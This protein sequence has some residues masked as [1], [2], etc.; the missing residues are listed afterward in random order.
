VDV[1]YFSL[2][3]L[4]LVTAVLLGSFS[5]PNDVRNQTIHTITT[6]PVERYEIFLGRFTGYALLMLAVLVVLTA[7]S[8]FYVIRGITPEAA[9]ESY[10]ARVPLFAKELTFW[11]T[12]SATKGDS[13]G[14]EWE[15]RTYISGPNPAAGSP[16]QFAFFAFPTLPGF[17]A[18]PPQPIRLEYA[19]DIFRTTKGEERHQGIYCTFTFAP[20][21]LGLP[22]LEAELR[23]M[24]GER[25][26]LLG[27]GL[28]TEQIRDELIKKYGIYEAKGTLVVDYH[29]LALEVPAELF[30][31][32]YADQ[33]RLQPG[34]DGRR[35][36]AMQIM[37]NVEAA[38][39]TQLL[40]VAR[41]DMY[42][43]VADRPFW[44][45]FVKGALTL[46]FAACLVL[47]IALTCSTYLSGTISFLTTAFLCGAGLFMD[48]ITSLATGQAGGG[49]PLE[50][51]YRLANRQGP[52]VRLDSTSP[53][54]S[55]LQAFDAAYQFL[56]R[57]LLNVFPDL[58]LFT[59]AVYVANGFDMTWGQVIFLNNLLPALGY[60]LPCF[61]LAYY[62]MNAREIANPT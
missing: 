20:G 12:R 10:H 57:L 54:V 59:P 40:G 44:V 41:R 52:A 30:R 13:V 15:Y 1:V 35:P 8:L 24:N 16:K 31:K 61:V 21:Q 50:S 33:D 5:I 32:L 53:L 19:F 47:G 42:L 46:W 56:L 48:Y 58:T 3:L 28:T 43:L 29:T 2:T 11:G 62:L 17:L 34:P 26:K 18:D 23:K 4:M 14:R 51:V 9:E 37:I 39:Q 60:M 36:A 22:E 38:S 6:K 7:L 27:K 55:A 49:G 25:E 45:N